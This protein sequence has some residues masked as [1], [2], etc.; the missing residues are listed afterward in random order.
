VKYLVVL[1]LFLIGTGASAQDSTA[2]SKLLTQFSK[3]YFESQTN[4]SNNYI[5]SLE[6]AFGVFH[7]D[8]P[9][10]LKAKTDVRSSMSLRTDEDAVRQLADSLIH[11]FVAKFFWKGHEIEF[12][13]YQKLLKFYVEASCPCY[14][15]R[16]TSEKD[17]I[18][19][20]QECEREIVKD[21]N[22]L[23]KATAYASD[24]PMQERQ[25]IQKF[26]SMYMY[27]HCE[28]V[29]SI[30]NETLVSDAVGHYNS[31]MARFTESVDKRAMN[32][33]AAKKI[34]SLSLLFPEYGKAKK[35]IEKSVPLYNDSSIDGYGNIKRNGDT[36]TYTRYFFKNLDVLARVDYS[37]ETR[38]SH[39]IITSF[40]Y[41][42]GNKLSKEEK[43]K[44]EGWKIVDPSPFKDIKIGE[45]KN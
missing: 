18:A 16:I 17:M 33:L 9:S 35:A 43:K 27:Q 36:I 29:N 5:E 40:Y 19:S 23:K 41:T 21:A 44:V 6:Y 30:M 11:V 3:A 15:S 34:D 32:Y 22:F 24:I 8:L 37:C 1:S 14:T 28:K 20:I 26:T 10:F 25:G 31:A 39:I 4:P 12:G 45:I 38:D 13:K 42:P 2:F 7:P